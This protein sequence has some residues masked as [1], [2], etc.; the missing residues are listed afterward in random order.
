MTANEDLNFH[1]FFPAIRHSQ[2][3]KCDLLTLYDVVF[4][5]FKKILDAYAACGFKDVI[6]RLD[7]GTACG[8]QLP[9]LNLPHP[10]LALC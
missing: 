2:S 3:F 1:H 7:E 10:S 8:L 4:S 5:K 9:S 6:K